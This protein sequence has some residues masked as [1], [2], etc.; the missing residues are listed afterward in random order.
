MDGG[1]A[2]RRLTAAIDALRF[3]LLTVLK[4]SSQD[5]AGLEL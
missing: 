4:Q 1:L 5:I 3:L 2:W